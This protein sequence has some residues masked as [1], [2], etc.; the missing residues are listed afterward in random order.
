M[1]V[2][3][4]LPD[5]QINSGHLRYIPIQRQEYKARLQDQVKYTSQ[6]QKE[7]KNTAVIGPWGNLGLG[8]RER[9]E[10]CKTALPSI[11]AGATDAESSMRRCPAL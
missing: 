6:G 1:S 4:S 7:V 2:T 3:V 9:R 11:P 8:G 10:I 5:K